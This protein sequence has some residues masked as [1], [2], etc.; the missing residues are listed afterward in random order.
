MIILC[1]YY[2]NIE[3]R[4]L[5]P[6]Q[7]SQNWNIAYLTCFQYDLTAYK[8]EILLLSKLGFTIESYLNGI[9][10]ENG[11]S[12]FFFTNCN[13][14]CFKAQGTKLISLKPNIHIFHNTQWGET[15]SKE[16]SYFLAST[17]T[18]FF[19]EKKCCNNTECKKL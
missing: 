9:K 7:G 18:P 13:I 4:I 8:N 6:R 10:H 5:I 17:F 11:L 1:T 2:V 15:F 16:H 3:S 14:L 12:E 19:W